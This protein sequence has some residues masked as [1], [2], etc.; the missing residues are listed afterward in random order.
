MLKNLKNIIK[1]FISHY[2]KIVKLQTGYIGINIIYSLLI[3]I[4][5]VLTLLLR[6]D[7]FNYFGNYS[8]LLKLIRFSGIFYSL[9]LGINLLC[10][11]TTVLL[12]GIP[13]FLK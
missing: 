4:F 13:F 2:Y 12:K 5:G 6:E 3:L 9:F 11:I 7:I 8:N 10:R 1:S